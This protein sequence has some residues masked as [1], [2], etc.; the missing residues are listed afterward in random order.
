VTIVIDKSW[1]GASRVLVYGWMD[2]PECGVLYCEDHRAFYF[3]LVD[4][5]CRPESPIVDYHY[6]QRVFVLAPLL[7]SPSDSI[8][9]A[10][11]AVDPCVDGVVFP[12]NDS[13]DAIGRALNSVGDVHWIAS[14]Y[15]MSG[16]CRIVVGNDLLRPIVVG[17]ADQSRE[18]YYRKLVSADNVA[19]Q[20][21]RILHEDLGV[22]YGLTV[23]TA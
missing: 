22:L 12:S 16:T 4:F 15:G 10:A 5:F 20:A 18:A 13:W 8:W 17:V 23:P 14:C 1:L 3:R 19:T 7:S 11:I 6:S 9:R 2:G 21:L